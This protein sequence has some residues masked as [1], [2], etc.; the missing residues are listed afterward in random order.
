VVVDPFVVA[1]PHGHRLVRSRRPARLTDLEGETALLLEDG[2]CLR[3]QALALCARL[4]VREAEFRATSLPTLVQ[5]VL[6]GAGVTL[7][8]VMSLPVENRRGAL[9]IRRFAAPVPG[10]AIQLVWRRQASRAPALEQVALALREA[11]ESPRGPRDERSAPR[12]VDGDSGRG[13]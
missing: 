5:M 13:S 9:V 12:H 2:H 10:R 8:P 6:G 3:D 11:A 7:L 1:A 4:D